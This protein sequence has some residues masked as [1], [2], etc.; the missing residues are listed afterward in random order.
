MDMLTPSC[1]DVCVHVRMYMYVC[2]IVICLCIHDGNV[3]N[4]RTIAIE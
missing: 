1:T 2:V 3:C 4:S